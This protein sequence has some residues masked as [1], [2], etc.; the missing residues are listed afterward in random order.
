MVDTTTDANINSEAFSIQTA[1]SAKRAVVTELP[2][3]D[4]RP[5]L[6]NSTVSER[7]WAA[8]QLHRACVDIGFF[9][10]TG[11]GFNNQSNGY[12]A[13]AATFSNCPWPIK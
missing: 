4:I 5:F 7:R 11:H 6:N 1:A 3:I 9:Y 2:I 12:R 10:L 8:A 13:P